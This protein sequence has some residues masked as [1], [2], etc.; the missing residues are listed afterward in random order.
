MSNEELLNRIGQSL[1]SFL[2]LD[3]ADDLTADRGYYLF[4]TLQRLHEHDVAAS[5]LLDD[6]ND[7]PTYALLSRVLELV[8]R[9]IEQRPET[10]DQFEADLESGPLTPPPG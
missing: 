8:A 4:T 9:M 1:A 2:E 5:T 6:I 3:K 10:L 7:Q